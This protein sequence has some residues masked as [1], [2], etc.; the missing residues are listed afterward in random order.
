MKKTTSPAS[1]SIADGRGLR[2]VIELAE[3]A[4]QVG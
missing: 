3:A 1:R 4:T 2:P